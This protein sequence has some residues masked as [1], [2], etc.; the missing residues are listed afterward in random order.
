MAESAAQY[1][2]LKQAILAYYGQNLA[3]RAQ[4]FHEWRFDTRGPVRTQ[5]TQLGCLV[6]RWLTTGDGPSPVDRVTIDNAIRQLPPDARRTMAHHHPDT[7]DDLVRQLENWQVA[8]QLSLSTRSTPR[9]V[10]A[11]RE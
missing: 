2:V 7:M 11:R 4:C 9:P 6:K 10:E 5:I 8:Q 1:P 3:A